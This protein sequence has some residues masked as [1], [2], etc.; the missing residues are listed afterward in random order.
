MDGMRKIII[1]L[2]VILAILIGAW[3]FVTR[4]VCS[5]VPDIGDILAFIPDIN[6]PDEPTA[7]I[8]KKGSVPIPKDSILIYNPTIDPDGRPFL[9]D[10]IYLPVEVVVI[11]GTDTTLVSA[12]VAGVPVQLKDVTYI[13]QTSPWERWRFCLSAIPYDSPDFSVGVAYQV[14]RWRD[15]WMGVALAAD[16]PGF[17]WA[18]VGVRGGWYILSRTSLD[19]ELGHSTDRQIYGQAGISFRF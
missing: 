3:F 8:I 11:E 1:R 13:R 19:A 17:R 16:V 15:W 6:P 5:R 9:P 10:T 12:K 7:L 18:G 4:V 14:F 2:L